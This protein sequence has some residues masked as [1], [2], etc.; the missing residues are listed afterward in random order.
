[1]RRCVVGFFL[2]FAPVCAPVAT[3]STPE[4]RIERVPV[5]GG[6]ELL[7]VFGHVPQTGT[8]QT[9]DVPLL[10]V[11]RDTLGDQD[12]ENDRLRYVWVL[13]S[14]RPTLV[15]R[16]IG[17]LPF[18][19]WRTHITHAADKQPQPVLDLGA[20]ARPVLTSLA[21]STTQVL[22]LD[23]EGALI[24]SSTRSYRNNLEDSHRLHL[25]EGLTVISGIEDRPDGTAVF[26]QEEL[27]EIETRLMLAGH[28]LGGLVSNSRL[29]SAYIKE[30]ARTQE[31]RG[32]NWEL[33]RQR[34]EVNGLYFEPFGADG[35]STH[36]LLWIA[37]EDLID[38]KFDGQFLGISDP[39]RD[40]RLKQWTGYH[41]V[42]DGKD[43]IPLALYA[44]DYPK[45]PLLLVDF[46]DTHRP[47]RREMIRHA[48]T[49]T[50]SGILG[51][52]KF[53]NLPFFAG[54]TI[55]NFVQVRHGAANDRAAR[56]R[57]YAEV[58]EWLALD[59]TI[60]P[61][62]RNV[63]QDRLEIMGVNP[64]EESITSEASLAR[65]QYTALL[66]YAAD[67][68]GLPARLARDRQSEV[69]AYDHGLAARFGFAVAHVA[70]FGTYTHREKE[71]ENAEARLQDA[72]RVEREIRFL[73]AVAK[74]SP[75][76]EIVWNMNEVRRALDD[77]ASAKLPA[78]SA[79]LVQQIMASTHDEPTRQ[80]CARVLQ[81]AQPVAETTV[82]AQQ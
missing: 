18:F 65:D 61:G 62:L 30:R 15:Q 74:S 39:Y 4:F 77:V 32:H 5:A 25:L 38:H 37:K 42:R 44:L 35:D 48:T 73:E 14:S 79:K 68:A 69:L 8:D 59:R 58:R 53:G 17:S 64:M 10:A 29:D 63:L 54:A 47:K 52:S 66:R 20:P 60:Q 13:T 36:A 80:A 23:P 45:V 12:P 70:T 9:A 16:A 22:A 34:A 2:I 78:G 76:P 24:R 67:P 43:M 55:F 11:L 26:T 46:R 57:S 82:A 40:P 21:G 56:L 1:M 50:V 31:T 49:D 7:T 75:S 3:A 28:T 27:I 6:A 71:S 51:I 81:N 41:E 72:R 33:L 19:Y